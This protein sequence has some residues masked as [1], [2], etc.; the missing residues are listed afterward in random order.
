MSYGKV[1]NTPSSDFNLIK[2]VV[3]NQRDKKTN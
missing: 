1:G 3:S 2:Q